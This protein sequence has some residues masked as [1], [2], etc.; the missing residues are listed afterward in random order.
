MLETEWM[1]DPFITRVVDLL[2]AKNCA[3]VG[4]AVRDS[5]LNQP[6][7]DI[8]LATVH[9]PEIAMRLLGEGGVKIVPTGLKHGTITAVGQPYSL[10]ITTLRSDLETD[11]RRAEVDFIDDWQLDAERRDFTINAIYLWPN[12]K[13]LD[14]VGGL[15]DL[16]ERRVRFIGDP[17]KRINEDALR[18]LRFY[19][20]SARLSLKL[21]KAGNEACGN[22]AD[23][24]H[25]LSMERVR[26]ELLKLLHYQGARVVLPEMARAGILAAIFPE[27]FSLE[28]LCSLQ[29]E[30]P[31][32]RLPIS[33]LAKLWLVTH[34]FYSAKTLAQ[35]LRLSGKQQFH[36]ERLDRFAT[37]LE[38]FEE[39]PAVW[40]ERGVRKLIYLAAAEVARDIMG[41]NEVDHAEILENWQV[42]SF[43]LTGA[44]LKEIG[45]PVGPEMGKLLKRLEQD[46]IE[47]DFSLSKSDLIESI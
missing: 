3:F 13:L 37:N 43:P 24:L 30:G 26:S 8:D 39:G 28:Q 35:Y 21:D 23:H 16:A 32:E 46:W 36:L 2:G 6:V 12:G 25:N 31:N 19:R 18:I 4:G 15:E 11:G 1:S 27:G 41:M 10:E 33:V 7:T 9:K 17:E 5:L 22:N 40:S 45:V 34:D 47:S 14:P 42:P 20:F 38:Q 29:L 44:T